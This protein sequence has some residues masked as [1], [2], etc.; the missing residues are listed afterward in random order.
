MGFKYDCVE[1]R[2][3]IK[4]TSYRT[5]IDLDKLLI[6][7][8]YHNNKQTRSFIR[9]HHAVPKDLL[10]HLDR[11]SKSRI[12]AEYYLSEIIQKHRVYFENNRVKFAGL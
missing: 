3:G 1:E 4:K 5:H 2:Y 6:I 9:S 12:R 10:C 11:L 8:I 7:K